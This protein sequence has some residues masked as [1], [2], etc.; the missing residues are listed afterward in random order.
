[1]ESPDLR[2]ERKI[3]LYEALLKSQSEYPDIPKNR[4]GRFKYVDLDALIKAVRPILNK[5]GVYF[6]QDEVFV[7]TSEGIRLA[8]ITRLIHSKTGQATEFTSLV[9]TREED[10]NGKVTP[11]VYG[12]AYTYFKR[13]SLGSKL[14]ICTDDDTDGVTP[15]KHSYAPKKQEYKTPTNSNFF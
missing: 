15:D 7:E 4:S 8:I 5:N 6:E 12:S 9:P 10:F 1:M 3:D 14:G 11:Q 2:F 13:Y